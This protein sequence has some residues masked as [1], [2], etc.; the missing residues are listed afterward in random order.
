MWKSAIFG[1]KITENLKKSPKNIKG[2]TRGGQGGTSTNTD[3]YFAIYQ[4]GH[5]FRQHGHFSVPIF[6][7]F[8]NMDKFANTDNLV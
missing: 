1:P 7:S 3:I 2:G 5:L 6:I 8:A 4:R